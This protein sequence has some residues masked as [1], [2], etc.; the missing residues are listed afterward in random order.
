MKEETQQL[1][2]RKKKASKRSFSTQL[3]GSCEQLLSE[4]LQVKL[5]PKAC[6]KAL[7]WGAKNLDRKKSNTRT[8]RAHKS[9][10]S[11]YMVQIKKLHLQQQKSVINQTNRPGDS[12][13][14]MK[15][16]LFLHAYNN[17]VITNYGKTF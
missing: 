6:H 17:I 10:D 1:F 4:A 3:L 13:D 7:T 11:L 14:S 12:I 2:K 16:F 15:Y 8:T 5:L 9:D